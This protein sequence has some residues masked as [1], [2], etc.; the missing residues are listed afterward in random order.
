M[1]TN[2]HDAT[3]EALFAKT[4][5]LPDDESFVTGVAVQAQ[6]LKRQRLWIRIAL[7]FMLG[8]IAVPLQDVAI[9][10]TQFLV[11]SV[12]EVDAGL[13]AILLAPVNTVAGIASIVLLV[14]R[15]WRRLVFR[16]TL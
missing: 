4:N 15:R 2:H 13:T 10:A 16:K 14:M 6:R 7:G 11:S 3:L 12:V 5:A 1:S 9:L 8:L